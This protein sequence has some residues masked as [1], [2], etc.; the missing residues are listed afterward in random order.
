M[1]LVG[2]VLDRS[3]LLLL[4]LRSRGGLVG[5]ER[6]ERRGGVRVGQVERLPVEDAVLGIEEA[7][8]RGGDLLADMHGDGL[9]VGDVVAVEVDGEGVR[10]DEALVGD[11]PGTELGVLRVT[12]REDL[13]VGRLG[14]DRRVGVLHR[15][16][17]DQVDD[18]SARHPGS[19]LH[20]RVPDQGPVPEV[21]RLRAVDGVHGRP[22][23]VGE[24]GVRLERDAHV[25]HLPVHLHV[26]PHE[27]FTGRA[28][29]AAGLQDVHRA[30][31]DDVQGGELHLLAALQAGAVLGHRGEREREV[32]RVVA[33]V[34][35]EEGGGDVLVVDGL[36]VAGLGAMGVVPGRG[37][38]GEGDGGD[39]AGGGDGGGQVTEGGTTGTDDGHGRSSLSRPD[40][41]GGPRLCST[42]GPGSTGGDASSL[43]AESLP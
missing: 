7:V 34:G 43:S 39:E 14:H 9:D 26:V 24:V 18:L 25:Q 3:G 29:R 38:A 2:V 20:G 15:R 40:R 42:G 4:V 33:V 21:G 31:V 23:I 10:T 13:T 11:V 36:E 1:L 30:A 37:G 27:A 22:L 17:G 28:E 16:R 19:Q 6:G 8:V 12:E 41:G 35:L 5:P 32:L